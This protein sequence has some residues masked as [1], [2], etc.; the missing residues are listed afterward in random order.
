MSRQALMS[1]PRR[2][3]GA[4]DTEGLSGLTMRNRQ[5]TRVEAYVAL[6][7]TYPTRMLPT[8]MVDQ[9]PAPKSSCRCLMNLATGYAAK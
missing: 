3:D 2:G 1:G 8:A 5:Q 9:V 7:T 6:L 4:A